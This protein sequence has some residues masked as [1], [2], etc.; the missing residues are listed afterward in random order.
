MHQGDSIFANHHTRLTEQE[1]EM[2]VNTKT[3]VTLVKT[4]KKSNKRAAYADNFFTSFALLEYLRDN[5][6]CQ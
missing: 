2:L 1:S 5:P 6:G 4:L 3:V